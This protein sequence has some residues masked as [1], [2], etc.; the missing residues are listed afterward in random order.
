MINIMDNLNLIFYENP[1]ARG[2]LNTF[3]DKGRKDIK[4]VYYCNFSFFEIFRKY[5]FK[6]NN[7]FPL[8]FIRDKRLRSLINQVEKFFS[9]RENF[10][11]DMYD[12][13][14]INHFQNISYLSTQSINSKKLIIFL[15]L[16]ND[17][18]FLIS[19]HELVRELL[20]TEK[21]FFHFHP[22]YLPKVR[23]ADGSLHS[24]LN[25]NEL[26]CTLFKLVKK[27]DKGPIIKRKIYKFE[28]FKLSNFKNFNNKELYRIWF[29]F[30][31]PALR[32]SML[33]ETLDQETKID[34]IINVDN[35]ED[36]NYYTFMNDHELNKVFE[37]IFCD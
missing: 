36:T 34:K 28:K 19:H 33:C 17:T 29:S 1:I 7:H 15:N 32:C 2:Y 26:G 25:H 18:N 6:K 24:I 5:V 20:N 4:I 16:S 10:L 31:D 13:N 12:Y 8:L 9:L 21:Q 22:G 37:K 30:V 35:N 14:N 11:I 3:L 23:G 27:I